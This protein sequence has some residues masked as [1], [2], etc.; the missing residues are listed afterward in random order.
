VAGGRGWFDAATAQKQ[1][2]GDP[3][4]AQGWL[5]VLGQSKLI[6]VGL[7][8]QAPEVDPGG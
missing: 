4:K 3:D 8:E 1:G 2:E 7:R 6:V 5:G